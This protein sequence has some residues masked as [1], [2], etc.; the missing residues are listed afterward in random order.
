MRVVSREAT[1][2]TEDV[3]SCCACCA[4]TEAH[5]P[6]QVG[7]AFRICNAL[8]PFA[9]LPLPADNGPVAAWHIRLF[10]LFGLCLIAV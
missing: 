6:R 4:L 7:V 1:R 10:A 3:G 5:A 9:I 8:H 2:K